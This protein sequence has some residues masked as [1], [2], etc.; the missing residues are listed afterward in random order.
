VKVRYGDKEVSLV[1][2]AY[3]SL[4]NNITDPKNLKEV[5]HEY[6]SQGLRNV[7]LTSA[8]DGGFFDDEKPVL[9]KLRLLSVM[10]ISDEVRPDCKRTMDL[11]IAGGLEIRILSGDDPKAV[12]ALFKIAGLPGERK[13]LSGDELERL[14]GS[15]RTARIM[16]TNIFGRMKPDQKESVIEELKRN[17]RY[18]AMVGDGVNDVK[19]LKEAQ[20]GIALQSGSGA[21][22]GVADMVLISDDFSA[23]PKALTE[24]NRTVSGMRDILK[25]YLARNFV[26][27]MMIILTVLIFSAPP[28][29]PITNTIYAFFGLSIASF[30]MV[31]W[32]KPS[33]IEGSI[34]PEVL[35]YAIPTALLVSLFGILLYV[36]FY[37]DF[38]HDLLGIT[39]SAEQLMEF[40]WKSA[41][42]TGTAG[43]IVARNALLVFL[44]MTSLLQILFVAP[45]FRFFS[46]DGR[47]HKDLKPTIL[48]IL[49]ICLI[50]LVYWAISE[51]GSTYP[52]IVTIST[53]FLLPLSAYIIITGFLVAWFLMTRWVLRNG[54]LERFTNFTEWLYSLQLKSVRKKHDRNSERRREAQ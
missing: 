18:V 1:L 22:R 19:S 24:G 25:M 5:V 51:Y 40:N 13:V 52:A 28:L 49:L 11:F 48:A 10:A 20:V 41:D 6:S 50:C 8:E 7:V 44:I 54:F 34:L 38:V 26:I 14:S 12:D 37:M 36:L 9:P 39:L 46:V 21:A 43:E 27:A 45:R 2:G 16:E 15:E 29:V 30:F 17:G 47:I 53:I 31:I 33:K 42:I 35:R 23:L 3:D 4:I 32:A